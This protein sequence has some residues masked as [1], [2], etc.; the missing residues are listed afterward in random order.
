MARENPTRNAI[1]KTNAAHAPGTAPQPHPTLS[2]GPPPAS[3]PA[4]APASAPESTPPSVS[5]PASGG[6]QMISGG[7]AQRPAAQVPAVHSVPASHDSPASSPTANG[8]AALSMPF[9]EA[10][11]TYHPVAVDG[12]T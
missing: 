8:C 10:L 5:D 7:A 6:I 4:S 1:S 3:V 12:G 2:G 11:S 9:T